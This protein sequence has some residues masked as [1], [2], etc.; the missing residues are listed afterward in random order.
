[1]ILFAEGILKTHWDQSVP[2]NVARIA[3]AM[4]VVV[5]PGETGDACAIL[6]ITPQ[7]TRRVTIASRDSF[8]RQRYGVAHAMGHIAL[9]HL[10][11]GMRREIMVSESYHVDYSLRMES[12]A[13]DFAL[14]LLI[15]TQVLQFTLTEG[16]AES[17]QELA[18]LFEVP[19]ILVKQRLADL[20]LRLPQ[21]LVRQL[22][23]ETRWDA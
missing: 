14:R 3:R 8:M 19:D 15:P 13:N 12:E 21:S 5:A 20:D 17:L 9:H 4:S 6:E 23:A 11:P 10:R 7:R 22:R 2:V 18:H 16:H 1:M